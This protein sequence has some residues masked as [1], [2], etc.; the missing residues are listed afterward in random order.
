MESLVSGEH[1]A[2]ALIAGLIIVLVLHLLMKMAEFIFELFNKKNEVTQKNIDNLITSLSM[3]IEALHR[4][5]ERMRSVETKLAEISKLK[6]EFT[7]LRLALKIL[8]G[9]SWSNIRKSIAEDEFPND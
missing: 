7:R 9:D 6:G 1:G 3:N 2:T 4:L 8:A 5:E